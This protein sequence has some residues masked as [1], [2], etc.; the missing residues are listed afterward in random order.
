MQY[1]IIHVYSALFE[2][3]N[4]N[5][6]KLITGALYQ[7]IKL[8]KRIRKHRSIDDKNISEYHINNFIIEIY[9]L[10]KKDETLRHTFSPLFSNKHLLIASRMIA[11][12]S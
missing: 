7:F 12:I 5:L 11:F 9:F 6:E 3:K 2:L 10:L 4:M 1:S 8:I